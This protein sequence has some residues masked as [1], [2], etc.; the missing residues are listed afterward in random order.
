MPFTGTGF[1]SPH[2]DPEVVVSNPTEVTQAHSRLW[3]P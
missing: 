1:N 2:R 3:G